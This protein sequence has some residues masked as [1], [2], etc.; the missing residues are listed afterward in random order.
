MNVSHIYTRIILFVIYIYLPEYSHV[1]LVFIFFIIIFFS[2]LCCAHLSLASIIVVVCLL[3]SEGSELTKFKDRNYLSIA[4]TLF[5]INI[6]DE[7][8]KNVEGRCCRAERQR[9]TK[10]ANRKS[11]KK[12]VVQMNEWKILGW[13]ERFNENG[14][15]LLSLLSFFSFL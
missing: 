3:L 11:N 15:F 1:K 13:F 12:M 10:M 8:A 6:S 9:E 5:K 14:F 4:S 2:V 7:P